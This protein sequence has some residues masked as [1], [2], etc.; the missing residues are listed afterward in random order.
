M[1]L[2]KGFRQDNTHHQMFWFHVGNRKSSVSTRISHGQAEYSDSLLGQMSCQMRLS[3]AEFE[4]FME[5]EMDYQGYLDLLVQRNHV[6][7]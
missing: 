1:L 5:C 7:L 6:I 4:R 2:K 3:R